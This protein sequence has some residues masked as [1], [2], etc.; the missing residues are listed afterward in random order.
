[1]LQGI[2][3]GADGNLWF[4]DNYG[5]GRITPTGQITVFPVQ[6]GVQTGEQQFPNEISSGPDGN[7]W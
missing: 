3:A 6:A 4:T 5:I 2:T 7:L 1:V